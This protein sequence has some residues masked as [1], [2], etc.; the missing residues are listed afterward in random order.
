[1]KIQSGSE[2]E[3]L[4]AGKILRVNAKCNGTDRVSALVA[5]SFNFAKWTVKL[6]YKNISGSS[7]RAASFKYTIGSN[8]H[9]YEEVMD[10]EDFAESVVNDIEV[11]GMDFDDFLDDFGYRGDSRARSIYGACVRN[12]RKMSRVFSLRRRDFVNQAGI[13]GWECLLASAAESSN[14][15]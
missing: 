8:N 7:N 13:G 11:G 12:T 2:T 15:A 10:F 6:T 4:L 14:S 1:M 5:G 9:E 3:F